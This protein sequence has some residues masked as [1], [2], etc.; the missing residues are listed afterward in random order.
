MLRVGV[1]V[2]VVFT[3]VVMIEIE[4]TFQPKLFLKKTFIYLI[5]REQ[6]QRQREK[7]GESLKQTLR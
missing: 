3:R 7:G 4:M 1:G 6:G 5:E 2:D